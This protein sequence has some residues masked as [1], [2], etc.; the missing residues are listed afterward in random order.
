MKYIIFY[1]AYVVVGCIVLLI[2]AKRNENYLTVKDVLKRFI[3]ACTVWFLFFIIARIWNF[4]TADFW[5][6]EI[7]RKEK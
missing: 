4:A 6:K 3:L 2:A 5:D 7:W 1:I